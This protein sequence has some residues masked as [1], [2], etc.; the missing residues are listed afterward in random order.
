MAKRK[1]RAGTKRLLR[2]ES[3]EP[4]LPLT[5]M[6]G[7]DP[8]LTTALVQ[9]LLN[10][11]SAA[12]KNQTAIIAVVDRGGDILGVRVENGVTFS[13]AAERVFAIDGA[14]AEAR[15]GAFF[16]SNLPDGSPLSSRAV[17]FISQ[18]TITQREVDSSPESTNPTTQGPGIVGPIGV[19]GQFPPGIQNTAVPDLFAIETTNEDTITSPGRF[20]VAEPAGL[21]APISYGEASG[22]L[23]STQ[24]RGIGTLPGG[25][26]I[27]EQVGGVSYCIGGIGVFFPGPNG[28]ASY[29]QN[30]LP[31]TGQTQAQRENSQ[32][33]QEAEW[34]A[35]AAVGGSAGAGLSVGAINGAAALPASFN[36]PF[37][38]GGISL[39]GITVDDFGQGG[40]YFGPR[41]VAQIGAEVK[42]GGSI[43]GTDQPIDLFHD[44]LA[45]GQRVPYGW[46]VGPRTSP[47]GSSPLTA[48]NVATIID[49]GVTE[50]TLDRSQ[51]RLPLGSTP[52]MVLAVTDKDGNILGLYRMADSTVFSIGV[53]VAKAR[54]TAYYNS[55][56]L[57]PSDQLAGIPVGT[58]FTNRTFRFLAEPRYPEGVGNTPGPWSALNDP[59][60]NPATAEDS[61][62]ALPASVYEQTTTSLLAYA[63]FDPSRNFRDPNDLLNQNGIVFFPGSQGVYSGAVLVGGFGASGDGVD[64]DDVVTFSAN[65]GFDPPTARRVDNFFFRNTRLPYQEFDLNPRNK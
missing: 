20:N 10:R 29:E 58:A 50:A 62:P 40:N 44:T 53:A 46:L 5:A 12:D 15:T 31:G 6:Y 2:F 48:G 13:S 24:P 65:V 1:R 26:P 19:G 61:G 22:V 32:L 30:N 39:A 57:Q 33:D 8:V 56:T 3:L 16:S 43:N 47:D 27:Y 36:I 49:Q 18:S 42:P 21:N 54:N 64:E 52:S 63:A 25:V 45:T 4:R 23:P 41:A 59:G 34:M 60:I 38:P 17:Q 7:P 9:D 35:F 51:I 11:A 28:Y 37:S 14:V 55:S